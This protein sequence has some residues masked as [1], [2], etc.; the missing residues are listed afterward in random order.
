MVSHAY[1]HWTISLFIYCFRVYFIFLSLE[2]QDMLYYFEIVYIEY[3]FK[4]IQQ[5]CIHFMPS[6]LYCT[7]DFVMSDAFS[8]SLK[9]NPLLTRH[10]WLLFT[11]SNLF[12]APNLFEATYKYTYHIKNMVILHY[13]IFWNYENDFSHK[14]WSRN[15]DL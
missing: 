9:W 10:G 1:F 3:L 5:N 13:L 2:I 11:L 14:I 4:Q 6:L 12:Y 7:H 15:Y 8:Q